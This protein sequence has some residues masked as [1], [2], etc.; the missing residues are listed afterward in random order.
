MKQLRTLLVAVFFSSLAGAFA[1]VPANDNFANRIV[2][3]GNFV[4][5]SSTV[6]NATKEADENF[7]AFNSGGHSVWYEWTPTFT[8]AVSI[9][10]F[11]SGTFRILLAAYTGTSV[12][13]NSLTEIDSA[14]EPQFGGNAVLS[15]TA[16]AGTSY[17]IVVD[18]RNGGQNT[19]SFTLNQ[20]IPVPTVSMTAPVP[21][22]SF[23]N[24]ALITLSAA[25]SSGGGPITNVSFY[26]SGSTLI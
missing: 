13:S 23:T 4:P 3:S 9:S 6:V 19:F 17:K 5:V 21:N 26:H 12:S 16:I 14:I 10:G 20:P 7:H 11:G 2:L 24:P 18:G 15:F 22:Q 8:A 1:Q 25:A